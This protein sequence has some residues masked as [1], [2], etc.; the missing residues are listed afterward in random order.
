MTPPE[1]VQATERQIVSHLMWHKAILSEEESS[2]RVDEYIRMLRERG[3]G[4]HVGFTDPFDRSIALAFELVLEQGM[5]PWH[6]DLVRFT[7]LYLDRV[8]DGTDIDLITAGKLL[9]MAWSILKMQSEALRAR[10]EPPPPPEPDLQWED[11]SLEVVDDPDAAFTDRVLQPGD[12]PIDEKVFHKGDRKVTLM[13]LVDAL[14]EARHEAEMRREITLRRDADKAI[15]SAKR[16]GRADAAA[17]KDDQEGDIAEVWDR[18]LGKNGVP[19]PIIDIQTKTKD[20]MVKTLL[21]VLF[22]ARADKIRL[23]QDDFPFGMIFI[24]NPQATG[25]VDARPALPPEPVVT[26][27]RRPPQRKPKPSKIAEV[28][29][30][31]N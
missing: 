17:H 5:D 28:T 2:T 23:W 19:I 10:A 12:A 24:Q 18:I 4:Q 20:D 21:S 16:Q 14:E 29:H 25:Y 15:R 11:I 22:L 6:I 30:A 31:Q 3:E 13:E 26:S 7:A 1:Q 8:K 27:K 9:H